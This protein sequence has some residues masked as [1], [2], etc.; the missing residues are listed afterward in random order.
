MSKNYTKK[1]AA[2]KTTKLTARKVDSKNLS[3]E[4]ILL[5]GENLEEKIP[6]E[7]E[8]IL[9]MITRCKVTPEDACVIYD[10]NGSL[11]YCNLKG[12][13]YGTYLFH[14]NKNI[15]EFY[16]DMPDMQVMRQAF[17]GNTNLVSFAGNL[18][19][20]YDGNSCFSQ[21]F[22]LENFTSSLKSLKTGDSMFREC[23]LNAVSV[24]NILTTIRDYTND[25][26]STHNLGM[27][28]QE[29][30]IETFN[31]ITGN[32]KEIT[33]SLQTIVYKGWNIEINKI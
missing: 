29:S 26:S 3:A 32:T 11:I 6:T 15:T 30:A 22:K 12:I 23:N 18:D 10:D 4:K 14:R 9:S 31:S 16:Y 27:R 33:T 2:L 17:Y 20:L 19:S 24:Q 5:N 25:T 7:E 8:T 28:I 13:K 1:T 21:C